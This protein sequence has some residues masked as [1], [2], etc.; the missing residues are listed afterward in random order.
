MFNWY[1]FFGILSRLILII[2]FLS[3][4]LPQQIRAIRKSD[5][6]KVYRWLLLF[7]SVGFLI[8]SVLP[9]NY[10]LIRLDSP[11]EFNLL[12]IA[13]LSGNLS[14]LLLGSPIIIFYYLVRRAS[15]RG[16]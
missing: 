9:V 8:F 11:S 2:G 12:N 4:V 5:A 6:D 15:K 1:V 14:I 3:I 10:Q 16:V 13:S 7:S